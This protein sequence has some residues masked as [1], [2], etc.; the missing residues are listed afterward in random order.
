MDQNP[1][2]IVIAGG[3]I[4]G[5]A[6][7]ALFGSA[8]LGVWLVDP[9][10][11]RPDQ[12]TTA[13]LQPG[14]ALLDRA[15]VWDALA[16]QAAPLQVMRLVD[17]SHRPAITRDF[18]AAERGP[19]PFG[20]NLP[21]SVLR[22]ALADRLTALPG[23]RVGRGTGYA[24]H[25]ARDDAVLVRLT[26]GTTIRARLLIGADGRDSAVRRSAGI[27]AR[28][29]RYGQSALV[30]T[31]T[32]SVPHEGISTEVHMSRGPFTLVPLPDRDGQAASAVVWMTDGPEAARLAALPEA[33][34]SAAA[35]ERSSGVLGALTV[36]GP[37]Q[38]WP[39][40][41]QVADRLTA[42]RTA[43]MAEAAH[44]LPPI[45]AQGLNMSLADIATLARLADEN[46]DGLGEAPMLAAY[47]RARHPDILARVAGIDLLNRASQ[48]GAAPLQRL[49]ALGL[50]ALHDLPPLRR[51]AMRLGL[52]AGR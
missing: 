7:A 42:D 51:A 31:V 36:V 13:I 21:N 43:L 44:V 46:R 11:D 27:A 17:A 34:F 19:L 2:D 47:A 5:M 24:G 45:G 22:A 49:R 50:Q 1:T 18:D 37:R 28:R 33:A 12:R 25:V 48:A 52:G 20:W 4:A 40:I 32:H 41:A 23:V 26:D 29:L 39:I 14:Q 38:T 10:P 3:G 15:G 35:T 8:G 30:F 9:A 16:A 6:A